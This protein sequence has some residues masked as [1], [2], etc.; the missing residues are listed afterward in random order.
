MSETK[1]SREC[2]DEAGATDRSPYDRSIQE[3]RGGVENILS[4]AR[5]QLGLSSSATVPEPVLIAAIQTANNVWMTHQQ[6]ASRV[7]ERKHEVEMTRFRSSG[8]LGGA[9]GIPGFGG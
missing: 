6:L 9:L 5:T 3:I 7:A 8:G 1:C 2:D 4:A